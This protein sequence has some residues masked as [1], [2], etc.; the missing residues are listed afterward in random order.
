MTSPHR[1][2]AIPWRL[3]VLMVGSSLL[4]CSPTERPP[5]G[6]VRGTVTLDGTALANA[7]V[8]FTP[9]GKGRTSQGFTDAS[10]RYELRYL[11][12][13]P[14]ANVDRHTVRITTSSE[15]NGGREQLPPRYHSR[16]VL[17]ATVSAGSNDLDFAL[18]SH[19]P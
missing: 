4:G 11:R 14:G 15:E 1:S 2:T 13:I 5:L 10:G 16:T 6:Q 18:Q 19:A 12:N 8:L 7:T 17:E 9:A 3:S